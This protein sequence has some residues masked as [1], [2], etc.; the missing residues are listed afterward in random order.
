MDADNRQQFGAVADILLWIAFA[1]GAFG[2]IVYLLKG[3]G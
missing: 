2:S 3:I 1:V